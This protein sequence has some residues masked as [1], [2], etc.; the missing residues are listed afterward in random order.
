MG[1]DQS[2]HAP[3]L[4][5]EEGHP[6]FETRADLVV[7][8]LRRHLSGVAS[9]AILD[10][11]CGTGLVASKLSAS[12]PEALVVAVDLSVRAASHIR[13]SVRFVRAD[14]MSPPFHGGFD[15]VLLLDVIEHFRDDAGVLRIAGSLLAP[16]G[17]LVITVPA[18]KSLWSGFDELSG[19]E[20]RYG[21]R[22]LRRCIGSAGLRAVLMS[23][24]MSF[25]PLPL[26]A[27]RR[28][29]PGRRNSPPAETLKGELGAG[30]SLAGL[31]R[32]LAGMER[33][34]LIS[35]LRLPHG[36]SAIALA[37]RKEPD[38]RTA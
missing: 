32:A 14:L 25:L 35:G 22:D 26:F 3:I 15:A 10:L 21:L 8:L 29:S 38:E 11:G 23:C 20:R 28:L 17:R 12:M 2:L 13:P 34:M 37:V 19:H 5:A 24:F 27:R 6:W 33:M 18:M 31:F 4:E 36:S 1:Y 16:G 9:P 30:R 7:E